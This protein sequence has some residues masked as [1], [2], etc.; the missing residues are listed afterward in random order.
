[1]AALG[2]RLRA[3]LARRRSSEA[4]YYSLEAQK[5]QLLVMLEPSS[6]I[7]DPEVISVQPR[8]RYS[9]AFKLRIIAEADAAVG[10][11]EIAALLRR[12]GLYSSALT[13]F[14]KQRAKGKL[15]PMV[16]KADP[17]ATR[18]GALLRQVTQLERENRQ[19]RRD[20]SRA[21][22]VNDVQKKVSE[23]LGIVLPDVPE[24]PSSP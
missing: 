15:G 2:G 1:V 8:K 11:G 21:S 5:D 23:L 4:Y 10:P 6:M 3:L 16:S 7:P 24:D 20:L 9:S 22:L 19:L 13:E 12:E 18:S 17:S 14:R